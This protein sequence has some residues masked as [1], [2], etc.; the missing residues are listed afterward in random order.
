MFNRETHI[1]GELGYHISELRIFKRRI[2]YRVM[3]GK[4]RGARGDVTSLSCAVVS[5]LIEMRAPRDRMRRQT[6]NAENNDDTENRA[7][8]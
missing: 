5:Y 6:S 4:G 2:F 7:G 8:R 1:Q 3:S